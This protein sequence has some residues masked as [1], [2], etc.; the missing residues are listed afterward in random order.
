MYYYRVGYWSNDGSAGVE[1]SHAEAFDAAAFE[2][3][4]HAGVA[5]ILRTERHN[6]EHFPFAWIYDQVAQW[7]VLHH[8]FR[9]LTFTAE[10]EIYGS[11][12]VLDAGSDMPDLD[13]LYRYLRDE[14]LAP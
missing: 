4:V 10:Y 3:L 7:L 13:R 8:G 9:R 14:G 2:A 12:S 5:S 6:K 1:L 11:D